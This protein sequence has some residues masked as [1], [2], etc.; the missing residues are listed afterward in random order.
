V[1][2]QTGEG[3]KRSSAGNG[4]NEVSSGTAATALAMLIS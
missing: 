3:S 2:L 1:S 4:M